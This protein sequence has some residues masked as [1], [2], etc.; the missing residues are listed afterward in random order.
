[1]I[2]LLN[3]LEVLDIE[4]YIVTKFHSTTFLRNFLSEIDQLGYLCLCPL[5][6]VLTLSGNPITQSLSTASTLSYRESVHELI[7]Q[8]KVLD[9]IPYEEI[10]I[11]NSSYSLMSP[12]LVDGWRSMCKGS[13][14]IS[15]LELHD[16]GSLYIMMVEVILF[17]SY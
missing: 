11:S 10:D 14:S 15:P 3:E 8:L 12:S 9:D 13:I 17:N 6:T 1:M 4:K 16:K 7:P 5:L 2:S